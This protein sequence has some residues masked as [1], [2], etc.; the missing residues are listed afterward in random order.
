MQD[1][2]QLPGALSYCVVFCIIC[3]KD[4]LRI[5]TEQLPSSSD[6][7]QRNILVLLRMEG[8]SLCVC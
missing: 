4:S 2:I 7:H 8:R 6:K 3:V 1:L 5:V